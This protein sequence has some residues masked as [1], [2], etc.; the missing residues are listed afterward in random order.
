MD[1]LWIAVVLVAIAVAALW[2]WKFKRNPAQRLSSQSIDKLD[3]LTAW[4]PTPTRVLTGQERLAYAL[5]VKALPGHMI[6]AQVPL[7]RFLKVPTRNS[8]NEWL[9]RVGQLCADLVVC[10][11][12][13][14]VVAVVDVRVPPHQAS[15]RNRRRHDRM[16]KVL[17][18]AGIPLHVWIEN[19]LPTV[20]AARE[21]IL[22]APLEAETA[23]APPVTATRVASPAPRAPVPVPPRPPAAT[24]TAQPEPAQRALPVL[25]EEAPDLERDDWA[26]LREPPPSTWFDNLESGAVPLDT[27]RPKG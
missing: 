16:K 25:D 17:K 1:T 19:A 20:D 23:A 18:A 7:S 12:S 22:P 14:Q 4:E 26:Q 24:G 21:A 5:L 11:H 15:D 8:Y 6:L 2:W 27:P 13:S 3:T 9:G 10:D